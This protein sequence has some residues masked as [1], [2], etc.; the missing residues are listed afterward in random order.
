MTVHNCNCHGKHLNI[1]HEL[2]VSDKSGSHERFTV[3]KNLVDEFSYKIN[4][5]TNEVK[6]LRKDII[7]VFYN[8]LNHVF[9][10]E[11]IVEI[12]VEWECGFETTSQWLPL[13]REDTQNIL[14]GRTVYSYLY[15]DS[16]RDFSDANVMDHE[17]WDSVFM[18]KPMCNDF[19]AMHM[20]S[21]SEH[22]VRKRKDVRLFSHC[23]DTYNNEKVDFK[24]ILNSYTVIQRTPLYESAIVS[25]MSGF[26]FYDV[27]NV[28]GIFDHFTD[29]LTDFIIS[30]LSKKGKYKCVALANVNS[31]NFSGVG[32]IIV[33]FKLHSSNS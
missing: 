14:Q 29:N 33:A 3:P 12:R 6:H 1:N 7:T 19:R 9:K 17:C 11:D 31:R 4:L 27:K 22:V 21:K 10:V 30:K 18:I 15:L 28:I 25:F 5:Q 16:Q 32:Y 8:L 13:G 26:H 20:K 2:L 23:L 24:H